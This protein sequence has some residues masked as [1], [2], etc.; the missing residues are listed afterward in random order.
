[1]IKIDTIEEWQTLAATLHSEGRRKWV[2]Q[3]RATDPNGL[4]VWFWK[5]GETDIEVVTYSIA[6][7]D[8]ISNYR[9]E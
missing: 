7:Q 5:S 3:Y 8:A 6:V 2:T 4:H 1:M 9:N